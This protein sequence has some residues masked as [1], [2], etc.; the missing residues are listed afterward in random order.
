MLF[1][2]RK[3][4]VEI[5]V[6]LDT[7]KVGGLNKLT[8]SEVSRLLKLRQKILFKPADYRVNLQNM[9]TRLQLPVLLLL[10]DLS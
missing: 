7:A 2:I 5:L 3:Y 10:I 8:H 1:H 4:K 9:S 6:E